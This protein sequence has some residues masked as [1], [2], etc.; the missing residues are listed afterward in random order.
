MLHAVYTFVERISII[1]SFLLGDRFASGSLY[2]HVAVVHNVNIDGTH[3][4]A[5]IFIFWV[6]FF[7]LTQH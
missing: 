1:I 3:V 4:N 2:F 7:S 6:L 5:L